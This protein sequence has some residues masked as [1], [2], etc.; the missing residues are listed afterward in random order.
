LTRGGGKGKN[1]MKELTFPRVFLGEK[2]KKKKR[3]GS[4]VSVI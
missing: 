4:R 2:K 3:G 1:K